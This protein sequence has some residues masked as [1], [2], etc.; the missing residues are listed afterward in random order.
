MATLMKNEIRDEIKVTIVDGLLNEKGK[1]GY[2]DDD[3]I[4]CILPDYSIID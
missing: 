3:K 1:L 2:K 4:D